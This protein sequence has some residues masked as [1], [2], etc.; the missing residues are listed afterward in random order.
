MAT[1]ITEMAAHSPER[2]AAARRTALWV[3]LVAIGVYVTFMAMAV[4]KVG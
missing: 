3:A 1:S 4:I 2:R